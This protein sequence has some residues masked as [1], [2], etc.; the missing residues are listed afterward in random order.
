[1][2]TLLIYG[3]GV[4][5]RAVAE[6]FSRAG[7]DVT[8]KVRDT[9]RAHGLKVGIEV[10]D[11]LPDAAPDLILEF[12]A[13][14]L[15]VKKRV[16]AE[17]ESKYPDRRVIIATGT[18]GLEMEALS[19]DLKHPEIFLGIHYFMPAETSPVVEV[20]AGP[21]TAGEL[22]DEVAGLVMQTGKRASQ[23]YLKF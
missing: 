16:F 8:V 21:C 23:R 13:E 18:S 17:I 14:D 3:S 7:M 1:V 5:G 2:P 12:V 9:Q 15:S 22:V 6:T 4:M 11:K 10:V 20:M 19:E